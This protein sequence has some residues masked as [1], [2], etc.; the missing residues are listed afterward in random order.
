MIS[1]DIEVFARHSK[2]CKYTAQKQSRRCDCPKHMR[3]T[4]AGKQHR[5]ATGTRS[6]AKAEIVKRELEDKLAGRAVAVDG[7]HDLGQAV[8]VFITDK[9][10]QGVSADV[11][12][13]YTRELARLR[14]Y[15]ERHNVYTVR[16]ITRELITGFAAT[17]ESQYPSSY[18]RNKLRERYRGFL[19]YAFE[20]QWIERIPAFP[21]VRI[22]EPPTMPLS[23]EEYDRLLDST[24]GVI[25]DAD[26]RR[27]V[28]A[29]FQLMRWSGLAVRDALTLERAELRH[30][31]K[32]YRIVTSR[33]KTGTHVSVPIPVEIAEEL[34]AVPNDNP[35]FIFWS[36]NGEEKS[37][38]NNWSKRYIAPCFKAAKIPRNGNMTTHRLRDTFAVHYLERGVPLEDVSKMLGHDSIKTTERSYAAWIKGRQD[39]LDSLVT[40]AW[41]K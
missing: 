37:I 2:N 24:Y 3:W 26:E 6:W 41:S 9:R 19:R 25:K 40:G 18:T 13:K 27:R 20:A 33:Q 34:L 21:K 22:D 31:G 28:H 15:C 36:G 39:R 12:A 1:V 17:W 10:V 16:G 38:T 14:V 4:M 35:R 7:A 23:E 8:E 11:L 32:I 5:K 29:L 30:E